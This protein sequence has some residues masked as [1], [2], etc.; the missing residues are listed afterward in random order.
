MTD[1]VANTT[2]L[3][4]MIGSL[5]TGLFTIFPINILIAI[6]LGGA[7]LGLLKKA[8]KTATH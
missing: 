8:K 6:G 7:V 4:T 5:A 1:L 2:A 3:V